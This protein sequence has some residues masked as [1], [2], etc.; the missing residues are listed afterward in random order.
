MEDN[1][2]KSEINLTEF[3][4][5][6]QLAFKTFLSMNIK[7]WIKHANRFLRNLLHSE[8]VV[9][10]AFAQVWNMKESFTSIE[11]ANLY[12]ILSIDRS[13]VEFLHLKEERLIVTD[14]GSL[15]S[16][17]HHR[18]NEKRFKKVL[19]A[20]EEDVMKLGNL[21]RRCYILH[22]YSQ[23]E[24]KTISYLLGTDI[25]T[26]NKAL[27]NANKELK[28]LRRKRKKDSP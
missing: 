6:G 28:I 23:I 24:N 5:G 15:K 8:E 16:T 10:T 27:S 17:K 12:V 21:E 7:F 18:Y 1:S 11:N 22:Y 13:C 3:K 14:A 19:K 20:N 26:I 25:R 2:S 4:S 9:L